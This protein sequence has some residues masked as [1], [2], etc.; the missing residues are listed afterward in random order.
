MRAKELLLYVSHT[1]GGEWDEIYNCIKEKRPFDSETVDEYASNYPG[2]FV[3]IVDESY[4]AQV[5]NISEP[6]FVL[7]YRGDISLLNQKRKMLAV[8]GSRKPSKYGREATRKIIFDLPEDVVVVSGL[9]YGI[10][11][12][13]HLAAVDSG[14]KTIAILGGPLEDIYPK[15]NY[16]LSERIVKSGGLLLSEYPSTGET[17]AEHFPKRNRLIAA[18]SNL[19]FVAEAKI[20]SGTNIT[21]KYALQYGKDVACLPFHADEESSCNKLIKDGAYLIEDS[22]DI[23]SIM[24]YYRN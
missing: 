3:T 8:V 17:K 21:V 6:P 12:E 15:E 18:F 23:K 1:Y 7:Y 10:D 9:A 14:K 5:K 2:N 20:K 24:E 11:S 16:E 4:P 22:S 19:L 13:A